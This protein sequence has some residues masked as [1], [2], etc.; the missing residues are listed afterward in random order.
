[1]GNSSKMKVRVLVSVLVLV[2]VGVSLFYI[3]GE[4]KEPVEVMED[5]AGPVFENAASIEFETSSY[6]FGRI[7]EANGSI[8]H[9]FEFINKGSADLIVHN[10]RATCGCTTPEWTKEPVR[11]G[12]KGYIKVVFDPV[13]RPGTFNKSLS[14]V[15]NTNSQQVKLY[16]KGSVES[17]ARPLEEEY[18]WIDG[19]LR[20]SKKAISFETIIKEKP[21]T[22]SFKVYNDT[23]IEISFKSKVKAPGHLSVKFPTPLLSP[24]SSGSIEVTY[25]PRDIRQL[26][27]RSDYFEI[28][29][30]EKSNNV[31]KF[32]VIASLEEYFPP[33]TSEELAMAPRLQIENHSYDFG[34]IRQ[35]ETIKT[36]I[37]IT[38]TGRS[39]LNIRET[40]ATCGCTVSKPEKSNLKPG[41]SST[42]KVSFDSAGRSGEQLKAITV[43]SNDP[44]N[45]TQKITISA[46]IA[47]G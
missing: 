39:K 31:K 13:D 44:L 35:G 25:D 19:G 29:T 10:V 8:E 1:M 7:K 38:N 43:Y 34:T 4:K 47:K 12:E 33:M 5:Q 6:D 36:E 37:K 23:D 14:I 9:S 16:I 46:S 20:L 24:K 27:F 45:P 22:K 11:P 26:G 21:V 2:L 30:D 18:P 15:T 41:E 40:K 3:L 28:E 17:I 42:I 32:L